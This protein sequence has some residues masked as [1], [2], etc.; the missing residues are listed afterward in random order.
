MQKFFVFYDESGRCLF[1]I[2]VF[3][4]RVDEELIQMLLEDHVGDEERARVSLACIFYEHS[5]GLLF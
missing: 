2:S 4:R 5:V 3:I 1:V